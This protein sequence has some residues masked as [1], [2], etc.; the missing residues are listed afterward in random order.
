VVRTARS[1]IPYTSLTEGEM[2][3]AL[4]REQA[5]IMAAAY[6][7][8]PEYARALVMVD[9]ALNR[10]VSNGISFVGAIPDKLQA[11]AA[12]I[13]RAAQLTQ[14]AAA[15]FYGRDSLAYGVR[16]GADPIVPTSITEGCEDYA[17]RKTNQQRGT[18]W[19]KAWYKLQP[20]SSGAKQTWNTYKSNCELQKDTE[21]VLNARLEASSHHVLYKDIASGFSQIAGSRMD[22]KRLLHIAGIGGLA[23]AATVSPA[24]MS[25]WT[26]VGVLRANAGVGVGPLPSIQS[27]FI[28]ATSDDKNVL[29]AYLNWTKQRKSD[30]MNGIGEPITITLIVSAIVA[31]LGAVSKLLAEI[32]QGKRINLQAQAQGFGTPAFSAEQGD[33][34]MPARSGAGGGISPLLLLGA[35]VG[36]YLITEK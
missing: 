2:R 11:V 28:V 36:L 31:S 1:Y 13:A 23:S 29:D 6:P 32:N 8:F 22:I 27:G 25:E 16:I 30:K 33:F 3:L 17:T 20:G 4:L 12:E 21:R 10:G 7:D 14:P 9:N 19:P 26:E 34:S 15:D 18:N 24:I 35:G 5:A